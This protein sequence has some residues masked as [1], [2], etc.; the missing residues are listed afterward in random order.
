MRWP[1]VTLDR[2]EDVRVNHLMP[3]ESNGLE[4]NRMVMGNGDVPIMFLVRRIVDQ[5][6]GKVQMEQSPNKIEM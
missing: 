1:F 5:L 4:S 3:L 2:N 6:Q